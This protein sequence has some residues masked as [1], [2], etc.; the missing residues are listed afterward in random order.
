[1]KKLVRIFCVSDTHEQYP[2]GLPECD[3]LVHAGDATL[4]GSWAALK[5]LNSWFRHQKAAH[6]VFIP[7]NHDLLFESQPEF[8]RHLLSDPVVL[9]HEA[10]TIMGLKFFGSPW[11][12]IF[13]DWAFNYKPDRASA[14]WDAIPSDT[15]VLL[16]HGPPAGIL[17]LTATGQQVGC[18]IL[19]NRVEAIKPRLH[20]FGHIHE[21]GSTLSR[22]G[23]TTFINAAVLS[24]R[25]EL[26]ANPG[27]MYHLEVEDDQEDQAVPG[28]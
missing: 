7:G 1:M 14:L 11:T 3:I 15:D 19:R 17:D 5:D 9:I 23:E 2:S 12:P 24:R 21:C 13:H 4:A 20:V 27:V 26:M 18:V 22:S 8:A 25:H 6:K 28:R 10:T 16:T